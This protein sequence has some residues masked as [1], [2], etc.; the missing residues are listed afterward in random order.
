[1]AIAVSP[2]ASSAVAEAYKVLSAEESA[3]TD[4]IKALQAKQSALR[5]VLVSMRPLL[6]SNADGKL[7]H[8]G[9]V[10]WPFPTSSNSKQE[11]VPVRASGGGEV[12]EEEE[13]EDGD[14]TKPFAGMRFS[15]A[16]WKNMHGRPA[17]PT[18]I[19]T[20]LFEEAGWK[21]RSDQWNHKVNQVGVTLRRFKGKLFDQ[22]DDNLWFALEDDEL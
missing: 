12:E 21:F 8:R 7:T 9:Q 6:E 3:I 11:S 15:Q 16:L 22:N 5:E 2:K 19:I 18:P 4:Q 17:M 13:E 20:K 1:M 10:V 14:L